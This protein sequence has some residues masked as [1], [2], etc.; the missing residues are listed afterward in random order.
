MNATVTFV[1]S[2]TIYWHLKYLI[3]E[4]NNIIHAE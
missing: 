4:I 1:L 3:M 2:E